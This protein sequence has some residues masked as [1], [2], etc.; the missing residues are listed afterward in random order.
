[1]LIKELKNNYFDTFNYLTNKNN[2]C[3]VFLFIIWNLKCSI[4]YNYNY[5]NVIVL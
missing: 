2:I 1:M 4:Q 3:V 5:N